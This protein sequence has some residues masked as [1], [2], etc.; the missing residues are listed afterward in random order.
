LPDEN[1]LATIATIGGI[2]RIRVIR[3]SL[4]RARTFRK[5]AASG[6]NFREKRL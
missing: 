1:L 2:R 3:D 4:F 6:Y 5:R